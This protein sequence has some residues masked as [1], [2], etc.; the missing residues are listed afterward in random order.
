[1][2]RA[3]SLAGDSC[4]AQ[5]APRSAVKKGHRMSAT[6]TGAADH[7]DQ[8]PPRRRADQIGVALDPDAYRP[9]KALS[10]TTGTPIRDLLSEAVALLLLERSE[11]VPAALR[12]KV[13]VNIPGCD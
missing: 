11:P 13:R 4:P 8:A 5:L 6:Q 10:D 3:V 9:L 12:G 1:M 7:P 2:S